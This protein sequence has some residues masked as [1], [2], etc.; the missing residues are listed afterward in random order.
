MFSI[1]FVPDGTLDS[2]SPLARGRISIGTFEEEFE[3]ILGYWSR[4]QYVQ[5]W[6]EGVERIIDG[7]P[8]SC[9]LTSVH[10]PVTA[11]FFFWW[12][13]YQTKE[14]VCIQNQIVLLDDLDETFDLS[15]PYRFIRPR[16]VISEDGA[17]ISEWQTS[18]KDLRSW[19]K[20][21]Y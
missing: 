10:D 13:M 20:R 3:V 21:E 14:C 5:Q 1:E 19:L 12:P 9:L 15:S 16:Y 6:R 18:V 17:R 4:Q 7:Y 2:L 11:N 8:D